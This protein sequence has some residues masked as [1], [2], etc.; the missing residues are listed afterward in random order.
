MKTTQVAVLATIVG[1][2]AAQVRFE[3]ILNLAARS[4]SPDRLNA[5][6][7]SFVKY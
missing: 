5:C 6:P 4:R 2:L 7:T 3:E 1:V